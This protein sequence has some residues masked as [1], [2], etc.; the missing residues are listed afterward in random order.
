MKVD[1]GA[2]GTQSSQGPCFR[3]HSSLP[4]GSRLGLA[5]V[6]RQMFSPELPELPEHQG[7]GAAAPV[8][9]N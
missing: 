5:S 4:A 6:D 1:A 8:P 7:R 3:P 9:P 2:T